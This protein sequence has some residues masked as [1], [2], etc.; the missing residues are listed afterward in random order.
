MPTAKSKPD[1]TTAEVDKLADDGAALILGPYASGLALVSTQAAAKHNMA[2]VVDVG[3]VDAIVE[4]GLTN[5]FRFAP[6]L[7]KVHEH[8]AREFGQ[9]QRR[10]GQARQD[11]VHRP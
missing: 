9:D 7:K 6:G 1:V 5:T 2:N 3:V 10:G 11:R 8:G 4:R